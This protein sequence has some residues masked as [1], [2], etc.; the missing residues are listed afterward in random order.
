MKIWM[1]VRMM[2]KVKVQ[3]KD[4][5]EVLVK[6]WLKFLF[7]D[8]PRLRHSNLLCFRCSLADQMRF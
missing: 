7:V 1:K 2:V 3:V 6:V 5:V 8:Y 4:Q